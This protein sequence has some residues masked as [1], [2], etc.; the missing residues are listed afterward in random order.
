MDSLGYV[1]LQLG[2]VVLVPDL[3]DRFISSTIFTGQITV[4]TG[5]TQDDLD[6]RNSSL[7][8]VKTLDLTSKVSE[9]T[10]LLQRNSY[11]FSQGQSF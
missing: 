1:F 6:C 3:T 2:G 4:T 5:A 10:E 7:P 8:E 11:R 9:S